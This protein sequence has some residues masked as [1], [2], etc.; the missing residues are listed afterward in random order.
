ME[1]CS[2]EKC[3]G[4]MTCYNICSA[5]AITIKIDNEGFPYPY[6]SQNC[7]N[8]NLC[9]K[10]CHINN[11]LLPGDKKIAYASWLKDKKGRRNS[12]SGG[13]FTAFADYVLKNN[14]AIYGV[15]FDE[16]FNVIHKRA[17]DSI[18][19]E[20]FKGSKYVQSDL[21]NTF[22][23][24]KNDLENNKLVLFTGTPCQIA[25]LKLYLNK[26]YN[27]LLTCDLVCHGVPS[28]RIF[29][30]YIANMEKK[31][32]SKIKEIKFRDKKRSWLC[33]NMKLVFENRKT[34]AGNMAIDPFYVGYLKNFFLRMGCH[35]CK[36]TNM[37]RISDVTIA[38][39]WYYFK[40]ED[41]D[42]NNDKGISLIIINTEKGLDLFNNSKA[43]MHNY[44]KPYDRIYKIQPSLYKYPPVPEIRNDFWNDLESS[45]YAFVEDKY[46]KPR[47]DMRVHVLHYNYGYYIA[48]FILKMKGIA[49]KIL[50]R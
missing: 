36:Y 48:S 16:D 1:I 17:T 22:A 18:G 4:C 38:D 35:F 2:S 7:T 23:E 34:Y 24:A 47:K 37:D 27:N 39:F 29:K 30:E 43:I 32:N 5:N 45:G 8:C 25:A 44:E 49:K 41:K 10:C 42:I 28:P 46:L 40:T 9:K 50:K 15:A 33:F 31:Y 3:T 6:V 20:Q 26:E 11:D 13:A 12:T 14:G 19:V 21:K